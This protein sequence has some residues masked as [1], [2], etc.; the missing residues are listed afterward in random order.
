MAR[1]GRQLSTAGKLSIVYT[2]SPAASS[3]M[4]LLA[5]LI[6]NGKIQV[7][8]A[9]ATE[10]IASAHDDAEANAGAYAADSILYIGGPPRKDQ[11]STSFK[12]YAFNWQYL[13][14]S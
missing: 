5:T 14:R 10:G 4:K 13:N 7:V 11:V 3:A 2:Y 9:S 12:L 1:L 6:L 8:G